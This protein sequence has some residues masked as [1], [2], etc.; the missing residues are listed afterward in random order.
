MKIAIHFP[1]LLIA[2]LFDGVALDRF[3]MLQ[4]IIQP[5]P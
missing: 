3:L 5:D 1:K 2:E 4:N